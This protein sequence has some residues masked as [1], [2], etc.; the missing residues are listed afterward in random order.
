MK[1]SSV[2]IVLPCYNP[3]KDWASNVVESY[4]NI[5]V[6]AKSWTPGLI[7]VN[8]GSTKGIS[9]KDIEFVRANI[10][11]FEWINYK[12]NRGKGFA[13]RKG[14]KESKADFI[15]YTDIDF[16][17]THLSLINLVNSLVQGEAEVLAGER[18]DNYYVHTP[19]VRKII[20]RVL[21]KIVRGLLKIDVADTQAGLKGMNKLAKDAFLATTIDR[22]LF[23]IEFLWLAGKKYVISPFPVTLKD[24]IVFSKMN[25]KILLTEGVN[26]VKFYIKTLK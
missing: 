10:E 6:D 8:D 24:N 2:D 5:L 1:K 15:V 16:P 4:K 21:K 13:L 18:S 9:N 23:D 11:R 3:D 20:S 14:V 7:I 19:F 26:F 25:L 17:Y 12:K 22:Y